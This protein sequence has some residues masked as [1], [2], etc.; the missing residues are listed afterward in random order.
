M[1]LYQVAVNI[2]INAIKVEKISLAKRAVIHFQQTAITHCKSRNHSTSHPG[3]SAPQLQSRNYPSIHTP[4]PQ[5]IRL[6]AAPTRRAYA[7]IHTYPGVTHVAA[8][9]A[10]KSRRSLYSCHTTNC[11][12]AQ[13]RDIPS[14][15]A[16]ASTPFSEPISG[17]SISFFLSVQPREVC[18]TFAGELVR[19]RC[20]LGSKNAFNFFRG[21]SVAESH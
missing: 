4:P 20:V 17:R 3:V 21:R 16:L 10:V 9:R 14:V 15:L 8:R 7:Y 2:P 13:I 11:S 6:T 12:L 1:N 19:R 5:R 18:I